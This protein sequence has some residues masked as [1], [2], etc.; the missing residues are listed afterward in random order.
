M[1]NRNNHLNI[2]TYLLK[3]RIHNLEK[4]IDEQSKS[5]ESSSLHQGSEY[6]NGL[7][8]G[9]LKGELSACKDF[10]IMLESLANLE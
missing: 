3:N 8:N 7:H 9:Y 10:Y 5:N 6:Y 4:L 2:S 1:F